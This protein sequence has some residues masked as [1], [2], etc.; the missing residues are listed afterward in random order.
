MNPSKKMGMNRHWSVENMNPDVTSYEM[1][2][3]ICVSPK[4]IQASYFD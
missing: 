2:L 4:T 3:N 1:S